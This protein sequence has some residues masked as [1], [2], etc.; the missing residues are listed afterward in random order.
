M[1]VGICPICGAQVPLRMTNMNRHGSLN[2]IY[3]LVWSQV[4]N[5]WVAVAE[6]VKGRGKGKNTA[7]KLVA[8][9]L[10][11][12]AVTWLLPEAIAGPTNGTVA[13]GSAQITQSGTTTTITQATQYAL[14]NWGT[15]NV[16]ANETVNFNQPSAAD[17]AVNQIADTNAS[18]IYGQINARGE[19][20]LINPN[21]IVF[22]KG[23]QVNVG[24]MV[25]S[26]LAVNS[27]D[28]SGMHFSGTGNVANHGSITAGSHVVLLGSSVTNDGSISTAPLGTIIL[29]AG[30]SATLNLNNS[31]VSLKIDGSTMQNLIANG[32]LIQADAGHII[33]TAGA[34]GE[35][36]ASV[37]NNTGLVQARTVNNQN[38]TISLLADKESGPNTVGGTVT[39]G[40][41][42]DAS[43][44]DGGNGGNIETSAATVKTLPGFIINT[45]ASSG[46]TGNWLID[47]TDFTIA[48]SG[49]D[50]TGADLNNALTTSDVTISTNASVPCVNAPC[51]GSNGSNGDINVDDSVT[52]N[53]SHALTL[54]AFAN[55]N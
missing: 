27:T 28:S 9:A 33:M 31:Q 41:T 5:S 4:T 23:A 12:W 18:T 29:G 8:T 37:A 20:F 39:V 42:L 16:A 17:V 10:A 25:A 49:G 6:N 24:G 34:I 36:Q 52:W 51:P 30:N 45:S 32:G 35:L 26:A 19:I 11:L 53:T 43:A 48:P 2:R 7:R 22:G 14:L 50:M 55:I 47:P 40:G 21:G 15:F 44:P 1:H 46:K 54:N 13:K 38:G 3:R